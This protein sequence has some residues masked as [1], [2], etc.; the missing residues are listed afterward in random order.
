MS[1]K[2][3]KEDTPKR[4]DRF[5]ATLLA[6]VVVEFLVAILVTLFPVSWELTLV[7]ANVVAAL[8]VVIFLFT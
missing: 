1:A 7:I 6:Y 4:L 3:G 8:F 2:G 5:T